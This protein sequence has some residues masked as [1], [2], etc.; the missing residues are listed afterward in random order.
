MTAEELA[1]AGILSAVEEASAMATKPAVEITQVPD[2]RE[3][4]ENDSDAGE[5]LSNVDAN[6]DELVAPKDFYP[7]LYS[8]RNLWLLLS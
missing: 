6:I 2:A 5:D 8:L 7:L 4:G 3:D 1:A